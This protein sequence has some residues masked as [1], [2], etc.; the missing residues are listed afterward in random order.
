MRAGQALNAL[1]L[2]HAIDTAARPAIR[3]GHEDLVVLL[4]ELPDLRAQLIR[5]LLGT[6]V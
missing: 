5:D 2:E 3:I 6:V 1:L 4:F